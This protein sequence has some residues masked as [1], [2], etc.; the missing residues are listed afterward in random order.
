MSSM[1]SQGD[2]KVALYSCLGEVGS[3]SKLQ[4]HMP[5]TAQL[6]G[7]VL[8]ASGRVQYSPVGLGDNPGGVL[9]LK[10]DGGVPLAA[11]NWTQKDRGKNWIWGQKDRFL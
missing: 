7:P 2:L 4:G 11:E 6:G 10:T 8:K 3:G 9:G 5:W 1:T